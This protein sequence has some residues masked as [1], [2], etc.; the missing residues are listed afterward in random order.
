MKHGPYGKAMD[1]ILL[2][3]RNNP[4]ETDL[5]LLRVRLM[6]KAGAS[7]LKSYVRKIENS[8]DRSELEQLFRI[9]DGK[10]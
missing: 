2:A 7:G 5:I 10:E 8:L 4:L 9:M 6:K 3:L 1:I